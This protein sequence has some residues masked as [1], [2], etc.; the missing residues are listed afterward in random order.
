[1]K[2]ISSKNTKKLIRVVHFALHEKNIFSN[3]IFY[4]NLIISKSDDNRKIII[5][6]LEN[7]NG[8]STIKQKD[9]SL[10]IKNEFTW[11]YLIDDLD[12]LKNNECCNVLYINLIKN[13]LYLYLIINNSQYICYKYKFF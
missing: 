11:I 5:M 10:C 8:I 9:V 6:D 2:K 7:S 13:N 12:C 1:M 4:K 3:F